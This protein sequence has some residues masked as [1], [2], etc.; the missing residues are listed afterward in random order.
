[1][2]LI[3]D[4]GRARQRDR[5]VV[6]I[7]DH[8]VGPCALRQL[9][10]L[11]HD[12]GVGTRTD[13]LGE[14]IER[15][16][17]EL[18]HHLDQTLDADIIAGCERIDVADGVDRQP[19][20]GANDRHQ[21]FVDAALLQDLQERNVKPF[22]EDVG[23]VG[24]EADAA[25]V[26][27]M[28]GAREE[29]NQAAFVKAGRGDDEVVGMAGAHPGIVGDVGIAR[30]HALEPEVG[31]EVLHQ[32]SHRID[33]AWRAG[34]GLGQHP[35]LSVEDAGGKV[36]RLAHD[37]RERGAQQRLRLLLDHGDQPVPHDLQFDVGQRRACHMIV[38]Q[39]FSV[40]TSAPPPSTA[41]SKLGET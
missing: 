16:E 20:V 6:A 22:H 25:D 8:A 3:A 39:R 41:Q 23:G 36:P 35:A 30:F 12:R 11:G 17:L 2:P 28:R 26:H 14:R 37:R 27:Q 33:M 29:T 34:D 40:R 38:L 21:R 10:D 5:R 4:G 18:V 1:M 31:D 19:R 9:G 15:V 32:F 24:A 7:G 13:V